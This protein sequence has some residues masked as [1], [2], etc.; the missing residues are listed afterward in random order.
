MFRTTPTRGGSSSRSSASRRFREVRAQLN[1]AAKMARKFRR[2]GRRRRGRSSSSSSSVTQ[3]NE[4]DGMG[5]SHSAKY[6]K[7]YSKVKI[8]RGMKAMASSVNYRYNASGRLSCNSGVQTS[9]IVADLLDGIDVQSCMQKL[10]PSS[11]DGYQTG[12]CLIQGADVE[13]RFTNQSKGNVCMYL[14]DVVPKKNV[15]SDMLTLYNPIG[16]W[17]QMT[18]ADDSTTIDPISSANLGCTPFDSPVF[19]RWW[20]VT[21]VTKLI[22]AQGCV[23]IHKI[24]IKGYK[25]VFYAGE[26]TGDD[27]IQYDRGHTKLCFA[28]ISGFPVNEQS[29]KTDVSTSSCGVDYV[30]SVRIKMRGFQGSISRMYYD[31]LLPTLSDEYIMDKGSGEPEVNANA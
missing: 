16:A 21:K 15:S 9:T 23:H 24:H 14:Y 7:L 8:P 17:N 18:L 29:T 19:T 13:I 26:A 1:H 4:P 2:A 27:V 11:L 22:I 5:G 28:T 31:T 25:P 12:V 30:T 10:F 3:L 20:K 6:Y